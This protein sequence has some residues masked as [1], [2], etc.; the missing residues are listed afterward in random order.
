ME[1]PATVGELPAER[2]VAMRP[3]TLWQVPWQLMMLGPFVSCVLLDGEFVR[4]V[5]V[6]AMMTS[7]V[8]RSP[9]SDSV[10]APSDYPV[11]P[12]LAADMTLFD[13]A[14]SVVDNGWDLAVVLDREV[15]VITARSVYRALVGSDAMG[16][17]LPKFFGTTSDTSAFDGGGLP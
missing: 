1:Q 6:P 4:H 13:A 5:T 16:Q 11:L 8:R 3:G 14:V 12:V 9:D 7:A 15:R 17:A 10:L 2:I